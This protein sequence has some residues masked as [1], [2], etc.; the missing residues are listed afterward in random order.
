M[1]AEAPFDLLGKRDMSG[2]ASLMQLMLCM[3]SPLTGCI[4]VGQ[5][6]LVDICELYVRLQD[7]RHTLK[8]AVLLAR[9]L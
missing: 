7:M 3:R 2:F 4:G 9:F 5:S 8:P 6:S 1:D